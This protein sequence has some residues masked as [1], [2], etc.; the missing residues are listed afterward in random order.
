MKWKAKALKGSVT[1]AESIKKKKKVL[2][3]PQV[4]WPRTCSLENLCS[5]ICNFKGRLFHW[6]DS[7]LIC[8]KETRILHHAYLG[9]VLFISSNSQSTLLQLQNSL[10]STLSL[11]TE[12][13]FT[14]TRFLHF[15]MSWC[16]QTGHK[17]L[18]KELR[19]A[20]RGLHW[21]QC[22]F[23]RLKC[24]REF[25][26]ILKRCTYTYYMYLYI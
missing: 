23:Q 14:S 16:Y 8:K 2:A 9:L 17:E 24:V 4:A 25:G 11:R 10:E 15:T 6:K 3:C 21:S 22:N 7:M 19:R 12:M 13:F 5:F 1:E 20:E 18:L 26:K